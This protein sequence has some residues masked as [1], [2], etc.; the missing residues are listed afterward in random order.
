LGK[1][2]STS[3]NKSQIKG[4]GGG[5]R[6]VITGR[7]SIGGDDYVTLTVNSNNTTFKTYFGVLEGRNGNTFSG[8]ADSNKN[9][10][11]ESGIDTYVGSAS[12]RG[13]GYNGTANSG[14][15]TANRTT[16]RADGYIGNTLV[17]TAEGLGFWFL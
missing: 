9:G 4:N 2:K 13:Y 11:F 12:L 6:D 1:S 16:G 17:G 10:I 15:F 5:S 3:T 7:W 14:T 8:Y